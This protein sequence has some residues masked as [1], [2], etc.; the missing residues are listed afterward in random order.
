MDHGHVSSMAKINLNG[1]KVLVVGLA[2]T[3][4]ATA[5]FLKTQGSIVSTTEKRSRE[6]MKGALRELQGMDITMEWGGHGK[7]TFLRQDLIV[8]SPGVDPA[9][10]PILKALEGFC[11]FRRDKKGTSANHISHSKPILG[12]D[13]VSRAALNRVKKNIGIFFDMDFIR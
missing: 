7:E 9:I 4:L 1:T 8:V 13:A 11:R 12:K 6:E 10:Q 5:T 3:G 2:R